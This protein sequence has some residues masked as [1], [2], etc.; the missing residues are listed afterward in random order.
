MDIEGM[1]A[2]VL[3]ILMI[4]SLY[5]GTK[6]A[7]KIYD[8]ASKEDKEVFDRCMNK[9]VGL[10]AYVKRIPFWLSPSVITILIIALYSLSKL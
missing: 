2:A 10:Y 4:L 3:W 9:D 7:Q 1:I 6:K 5:L 8:S